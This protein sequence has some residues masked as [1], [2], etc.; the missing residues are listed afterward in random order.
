VQVTGLSGAKAVAGGWDHSLA[1]RDNGTVWAWGTNYAGQLGDGTTTSSLVPVQVAGLTAITA[2]AANR[3]QSFALGADGTLWAWGYNGYGQLGDGTTVDRST[4]VAVL[5]SVTAVAAGYLHTLAL[6]SDGTVW[7]WGANYF[8]QLG[9]GTQT[10]SEPTPQLVA[11]LPRASAI[12]AGYDHSLAVAAD[13]TVYAWGYNT[14]GQAADASLTE[15]VLTPKQV[16]GLSGIV[17]VAGGLYD[18][19][20]LTANGHVYGWGSDAHGQLGDGTASLEAQPVPTLGLAKGV[21]A[22]AAGSDHILART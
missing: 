12:G 17:A 15:A 10:P 5:S 19:L 13:G 16:P 2:I 7:G 4:P 3:S 11:A 1:L 22:I 14:Y 20:A 18:S 9:R 6:R 8:G 21:D